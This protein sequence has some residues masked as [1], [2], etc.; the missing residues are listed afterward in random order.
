MPN[1]RSVRECLLFGFEENLL[2]D[3]EFILLYDM[4]TSKNPDFPYW[5]YDPF[6]LD[7][8]CD[9]ECK[10]EFRFLKNDIH[11]LKDVLQVPDEVVCYNRLV[12]DGIEALCVLLKRFAYPIRH[13][14][15]CSRIARPVPQFNIITNA[16]MDIIYN[17]HC[18]R[19]RNFNQAWLSPANLQTYADVIHEAGA[20]YTNCWGFVDGKVWPVCRPRNLQR[21]LYNGHKRVH[22]IK[23]QSV[24]APNGLIANLYGPGEGRQHDSGMLADSGL[25]PQLQLHS[26]SPLGNPLCIYGDLGYPLR[27]QL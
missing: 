5:Q 27:P 20:P 15:M 16:M 4:N 7:D 1:L 9:D 12:V 6:D 2:N 10:A 17:Q 18:H 13:S 14:D 3:E 19:L 24:V 23:F 25:L 21:S 22:A 8:L 26:R 11:L